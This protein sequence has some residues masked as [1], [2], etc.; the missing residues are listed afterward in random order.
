MKDQKTELSFATPPYKRMIKTLF[1]WL[2]LHLWISARPPALCRSRRQLPVFTCTL[3][4]FICPSLNNQIIF[5]LFFLCLLSFFVFCLSS[6]I[7]VHLCGRMMQ[8][9]SD[10]DKYKN[11]FKPR[12]LKRN[13]NVRI[14]WLKDIF[15]HWLVYKYYWECLVQRVQ[16]TRVRP[17]HTG[18]YRGLAC[19]GLF[20]WS[21]LY[22]GHMI[23][24]VALLSNKSQVV[25]LNSPQ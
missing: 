25:E 8:I 24:G 4:A 21:H 16:P 17:T 13:W 12:Y 15:S 22:H 9:Q 10:K 2:N 5:T 20:W 1:N 11:L 3:S 7:Y 14:I 6:V 23:L 19:I 18:G